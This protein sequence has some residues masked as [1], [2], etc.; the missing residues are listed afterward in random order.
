MGKKTS[1]SGL[2]DEEKM[3]IQAAIKKKEALA[4]KR[5]ESLTKQKKECAIRVKYVSITE[6][7][8]NILVMKSYVASDPSSGTFELVSFK[9]EPATSPKFE[10]QIKALNN[11]IKWF[12]EHY[13]FVE[14]LTIFNEWG[15]AMKIYDNLD[16]ESVMRVLLDQI[17][18]YKRE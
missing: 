3:K 9:P 16:S 7:K 18:Y 8:G 5:L 2:S 4:K 12:S 13:T 6:P 17:D 1:C 10:G 11:A 15:E 14:S